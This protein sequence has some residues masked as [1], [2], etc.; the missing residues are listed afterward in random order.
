M[1]NLASGRSGPGSARPV[2]ASDVEACQSK[3]AVMQAAVAE[4][5]VGD[6]G[7]IE[8]V[9]RVPMLG[10]RYRLVP[11]ARNGRRFFGAF[12]QVEA[13]YRFGA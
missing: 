10:P 12:V 7:Q 4:I 2:R 3:Q 11:P 8:R 13:T 9:F 1:I 5:R 6:R